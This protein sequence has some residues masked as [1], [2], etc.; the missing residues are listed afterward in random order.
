MACLGS[1][2]AVLMNSIARNSLLETHFK[3]KRRLVAYSYILYSY[4]LGFY[5][6]RF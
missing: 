5:M 6:A 3:Q 2:F 1:Y 4:K